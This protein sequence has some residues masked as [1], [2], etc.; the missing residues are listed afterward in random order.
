M[1]ISIIFFDADGTLWDFEKV[2]HYALGQ[3]LA[4]LR[5][6][7]PGPRTEELSTSDLD[8]MRAQVASKR[9]GQGLTHEQIRQEAFERTL[10]ILGRPDPQL[11]AYLTEFYLHHRFTHIEMYPDVLPALGQLKTRYRL[12]LISNGN[13][14]PERCGLPNTFDV[15]VFAHDHSVR[16]PSPRLYEIALGQAGVTPGQAVHV[17][18]SLLN[19]I[20]GAQ[21][22]GIYATWLN[23][24]Q[25]RNTTEIR[26]DAEI[27]SL[28][29]L[30]AM[31]ARL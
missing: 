31:L 9:R 26:P 19:D 10:A 22:A 15:V 18:D 30:P 24:Y 23:R 14:Y 7:V 3:T 17:G 5:R 8:T 28:I 20:V 2:L 1:T 29:E 6:R 12:G 13:T 16:K 25:Q 11:A 21:A 4:E 27:A